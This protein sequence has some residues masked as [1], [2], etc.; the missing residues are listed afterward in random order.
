MKL[1]DFLS[2]FDWITPAISLA[3]QARGKT[4]V[5]GTD[6]FSNI[7]KL[8]R[9]GIKVTNVSKGPKGYTFDVPKKQ[10]QQAA[11][12]LGVKVRS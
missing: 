2:T 3:N 7:A 6:R 9:E 4:V 1:G 11:Q 12:V 5:C 10:A 8:Q